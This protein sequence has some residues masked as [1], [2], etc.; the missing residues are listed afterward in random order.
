MPYYVSIINEHA[1]MY[2]QVG[3][4]QTLQWVKE[5]GGLKGLQILSP[6]EESRL[7]AH[8]HCLAGT[9]LYKVLN[10][11]A[12]E[13]AEQYPVGHDSITTRDQ[14]HLAFHPS[15]LCVWLLKPSGFANSGVHQVQVQI[16]RARSWVSQLSPPNYLVK[17]KVRMLFIP[18]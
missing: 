3:C 1:E 14:M 6:Q 4:M 13:G 9:M 18:F 16:F 7:P 5:V 10:L 8:T 12:C 17:T 2:P 15:S 11:N